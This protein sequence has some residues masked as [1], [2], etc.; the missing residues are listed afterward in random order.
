MT[1]IHREGG[2]VV[3]DFRG[4]GA[5]EPFDLYQ[6]FGLMCAREGL[7]CA[8]LTTGIEDA[9]AHYTLRDVVATVARVAG[10]PLRF[11]L[12][13]VAT[14]Q[15]IVRVFSTV[16]RDLG[17]LGCD[18]RVFSV[19]REA[20][21]WLRAGEQPAQRDRTIELRSRHGA[22]AGTASQGGPSPA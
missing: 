16:Q 9:D 17:L 3:V 20:E 13:L 1:R 5:R 10:V 22:M 18:A 21:R 4:C 6:A 2:L 7:H 11:S 15:P 12:A 8:L 19:E 14:D